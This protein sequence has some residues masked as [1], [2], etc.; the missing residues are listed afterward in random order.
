MTAG[1]IQLISKG[2][3]DNY[4][5]GN[6]HLHFFIKIYK[7][8][9]NFAQIT[10]K[11]PIENN[12]F[13]S[14]EE[15]LLDVEG[16]LITDISLN[17]NIDGTI[18]NNVS[19]Y[20]IIK[21]ISIIFSNTPINELTPESI[22]LSNNLIY[23][24]NQLQTINNLSKNI[25]HTYDNIHINIDINNIVTT[26]IN[27][28]IDY[29]KNNYFIIYNYAKI[30]KFTTNLNYYITFYTDK[31]YNNEIFYLKNNNINYLLKKQ[32]NLK[33]IFYKIN[34]INNNIINSGIIH[35]YHNFNKNTKKYYLTL[36]FWFTNKPQ[37][38]IPIFLMLYEKIKIKIEFSNYNN[39]ISNSKSELY[40]NNF[41]KPILNNTELVINYVL[42]E[43]EHRKY[44]AN[45]I[46]NY[47]IE[48]LQIIEVPINTSILGDIKNNIKINT[49]N[50]IKSLFW[51][52]QD[53][54]FN[55]SVIKYKNN[56]I[57]FD[58]NYYDNLKNYENKIFNLKQYYNYN[59]CLDL[60]TYQPTGHL[61]NINSDL[62]LELY[63]IYK[64]NIIYVNNILNN[65]NLFGENINI[66][67]N[68]INLYKNI[69]Y[70]F[71]ILID[72]DIFITD[73]IIDNK[74]KQPK[75]YKYW[76]Y[77]NKILYLDKKTTQSNLYIYDSNF[78]YDYITINILQS[79]NIITSKKK[80][81]IFILN[82]NI[83]SFQ[84]GLSNFILQ[85]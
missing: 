36:P 32:L 46:N 22:H 7:K 38:S 15:I 52:S 58:K 14:I 73:N 17:T 64:Q 30:Y 62:I 16:D 70:N 84:N 60:L 61:N 76:D 43:N 27:T 57:N 1:L 75:Y 25:L 51:Y 19:I 31:T 21:K 69:N 6:P 55:N 81:D 53:T 45:N 72:I 49:N 74:N 20:N 68:Q 40:N 80:M 5:I 78:N 4:L 82:Y 13:N 77:L 33:Q 66:I 83:L 41:T 35:I 2:T 42:L 47:L 26:D 48:R 71:S 59:F 63:P 28:L 50:I 12:F 24:S 10:I 65:L 54:T 23:N 37:L 44:I 85:I 56:T 67:D 11:K 29:K 9:T 39:L 18:L 3:E 8:Y 79:E 34:D